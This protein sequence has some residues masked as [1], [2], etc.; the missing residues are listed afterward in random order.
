MNIL[1]MVSSKMF[2]VFL[3]KQTQNAKY[4][5]NFRHI[6]ED[7]EQYADSV[8]QT[9]NISEMTEEE[10]N[11]FYFKLHDSDN[12][13]VLD[14][15]E[16]LRAA[17]HHSVHIAHEENSG[18]RDGDKQEDE[19]NEIEHVIRRC[20]LCGGL[21]KCLK[22][23]FYFLLEIIDDFIQFADFNNDGYLNY[24]EYAQAMKQNTDMPLTNHIDNSIDKKEFK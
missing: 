14:G 3:C 10:K 1:H 9:R 20:M 21:Q 18:H 5:C 4:N 12:N 8:V 15:L 22:R 19:T 6:Q 13:D 23:K 17:T 24:P 7:L 16:L 2:Y 11:F